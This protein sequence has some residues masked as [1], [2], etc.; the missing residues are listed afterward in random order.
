MATYVAAAA[1]AMPRI[2]R[3]ERPDAAIAFFSM[4]CG[5]LG[6]LAHWC[7]G[8][9]Y[10]I[11]L[12]GGDVPGQERSLN[13]TYSLLAPIRRVVLRR[14]AAVVA[15]SSGLKALSEATDP[16][17]VKVISNGVD[18]DFFRPCA[19]RG[20]RPFTLL[21]VGRFHAQKNLAFLLEAVAALRREA[22]IPFR[23]VMVGDGPMRSELQQRCSDAGLDD[24]VTWHGWCDKERLLKHYHDADCLLNPSLCEGM[25][26]T[27]L[28][29]MACA[30]PVLASDVPGNDAAV[31]HGETG[32]LFE[33]GDVRQSVDAMHRMIAEP[34]IGR[35]M[36]AAGR[37]RVLRDFS[38]ETAARRYVD[39][40][41]LPAA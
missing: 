39:L 35:M 29:A 28:E 33:L 2:L 24:V 21:F 17:G 12:R 27:V 7:A 19:V 41:S 23:L 20:E 5:P 1:A 16:V 11:S 13:L 30:L 31:V 14:A 36:G 15:N 22:A 18:T 10:V 4:P 40:F 9:P 37:R 6:L 32:T 25:P 26:N 38:W 8:I 34:A 3:A